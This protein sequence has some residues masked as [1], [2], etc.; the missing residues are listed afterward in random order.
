[1]ALKIL[2]VDDAIETT[3]IL[4]RILTDEGYQVQIARNGLE[5]LRRA[6]EFQP[7]LVLLDV[8]MPDMDGWDMLQRLREFTDV[9]VIMLT[10]MG[11]ELDRVHGLDLGADDYLT[12]PFGMEEL[13]ARIRATLRRAATSQTGQQ[14]VLRFDGDNLIIDP[15]SHEVTVRGE[16]VDVT[17]TEYKLLIYLAYNA[18]R[19]LTSDQILAQV[20]G[21]GYEDP[22]NVKV[23]IWSL[24]RKIE[25][26]PHIPRYILTKRGIGYYL[27]RI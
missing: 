12:K 16:V 18:G 8:M 2:A 17:A 14:S 15:I 13:K 24:R 4:T 3:Q 27:P 25:A 5:G 20:W 11:T 19:V 6:Y 7:D 10:A 26:D 9:P 21:P 23:Y 22:S 1:M